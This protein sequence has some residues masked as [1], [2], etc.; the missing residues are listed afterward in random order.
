MIQESVLV[1]LESWITEARM[2]K[3]GWHWSICILEGSCSESAQFIEHWFW[4]WWTLL[5]RCWD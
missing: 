3:L 2:G 4:K 5:G 1:R